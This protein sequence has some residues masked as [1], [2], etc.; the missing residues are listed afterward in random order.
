MA[1]RQG[2]DGILVDALNPHEQTGAT[3]SV[4]L[5]IGLVRHWL[6]ESEVDYQNLKHLV[7]EILRKP[8]AVFGGVRVY[9]QG[10]YCYLGKPADWYIRPNCLVPFPKERIFAVYVN[11]MCR[12]YE[13][14]AEKVEPP[15]LYRPKGW[16]DRYEAL[17]WSTTDF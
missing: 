4:L 16:K 2:H 5:P 13:I 12:L 11:P 17:L 15:S 6:K 8:V 3:W 7:P 10:G 9:E 14:Q 1:S